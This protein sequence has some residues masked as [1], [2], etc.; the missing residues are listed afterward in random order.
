MISTGLAGNAY[1][2]TSN[3][4]ATPQGVEYQTLVRLNGDLGVTE[5]KK[6][7]DYPAYIRALS[8]NLKFW[9][10]VGADA[11]SE[12]S[13]LPAQLRAQLFYLY[14]FTQHHTM[15]IIQGDKTLTVDPLVDINKNIMTGLRGSQT[16]QEA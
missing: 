13:P 2:S 12:T 3:A 9:T 10:I 1:K 14:E 5:K 4:T 16:K 8:N 11:A 7:Q 6:R 15:K